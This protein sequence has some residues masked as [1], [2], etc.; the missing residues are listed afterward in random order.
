MGVIM[1]EILKSTSEF[2]NILLS[3]K[4]RYHVTFSCKSLPDNDYNG[5]A[6]VTLQQNY[7]TSTLPRKPLLRAKGNVVTLVTLKNSNIE[8]SKNDWLNLFEERAAIFEYEAGE[9]RPTAEAKAFDECILKLLKLDKKHTLKTAINYL[10]V[11][12]LH[13]PFYKKEC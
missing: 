10:M 9:N 3:E 5:N 13:N 2:K 1:L 6:K 7:V 11:C 4:S 12:G 8:M